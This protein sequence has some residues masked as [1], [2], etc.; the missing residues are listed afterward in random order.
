MSSEYSE[1][2]NY[3]KNQIYAYAKRNYFRCI[4][5]KKKLIQFRG[6]IPIIEMMIKSEEIN[7]ANA[8]GKL[9]S[10]YKSKAR[11]AGIQSM[12]VM[13]ENEI[14]QKTVILNTLM[15][16][17]RNLLFGIDTLYQIK[18]YESILPDSAVIQNNRSDVKAIDRSSD[19]LRLKQKMESAKSKPSFGIRYSN[20]TPF[21]SGPNQFNL[22]GMMSIPIAPWSSKEYKSNIKGLNFEIEELQLKK[23]NIINETIGTVSSI[24]YA[25]KNSK[26]QINIYQQS[27]IPA[28]ENNLN[29]SRLAYGQNKED[30]FV[31]LD[32]FDALNLA[33]IEYLNK[34]EEL[35]YLQVEYEKETEQK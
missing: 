17:D 4:I 3:E 21:I 22:M 11:L 7:Y 1:N 33:R 6:S 24:I 2:K 32:A 26:Q 16:R 34:V 5:L 14:E 23:Q 18:N 9:N 10:I 29:S 35:L 25:I 28:L 27:I 8:D 13:A 15:N 20:M 12:I 31:V 30:L 19:I